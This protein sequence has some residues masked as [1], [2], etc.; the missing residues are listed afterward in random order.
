MYKKSP[1]WEQGFES[2]SVAYGFRAFDMEQLLHRFDQLYQAPTHFAS[3]S[4]ISAVINVPPDCRWIKANVNMTGFYRVHYDKNN[5]QALS[6]QLRRDH[7][8]S[9]AF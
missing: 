4:G 2:N 9:P 5:W 8:V 3:H 1:I 7:S 6:E